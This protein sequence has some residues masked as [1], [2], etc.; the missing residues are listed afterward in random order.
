VKQQFSLLTPANST[1]DGTRS[2]SG[3]II[4]GVLGS[5]I[6]VGLGVASGG[7]YYLRKRR[8]TQIDVNGKTHE[9]NSQSGLPVQTLQPTA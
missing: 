6:V 9:L 7:F 4:G 8:H 3:G 2:N 1:T 5:L